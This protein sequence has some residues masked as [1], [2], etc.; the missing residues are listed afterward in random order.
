MSARRM[1]SPPRTRP[2]AN[3][4]TSPNSSAAR[5]S[6]AAV[7]VAVCS[8]PALWEATPAAVCRAAPVDNREATPVAVDNREAAPVAVDNLE[9]APVAVDNREA[10]PVAVD[11][12]EAAEAVPVAVDDREAAPLAVARCESPGKVR[13]DD[14]WN[15]MVVQQEQEIRLV[16]IVQQEQICLPERE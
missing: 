11:N 6:S 3:L 15:R 7:P 14:E 5:R 13:A 16:E 4:P 10:A 12:R 2:C 1:P 9:A 8:E